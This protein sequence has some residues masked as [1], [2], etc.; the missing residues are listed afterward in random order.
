MHTK[1][2][3][4][5][6]PTARRRRRVPPAPAEAPDEGTVLGD[7]GFTPPASPDRERIHRDHAS[8]ELDVDFSPLC[9]LDKWVIAGWHA[10]DARDEAVSDATSRTRR[11]WERQ[12][13]L[14][15]QLENV[16]VVVH[17]DTEP[18]P[19]ERGRAARTTG[20]D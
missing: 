20:V 16:L 6:D 4:W 2:L 19:A 14:V 18:Q 15:A 5:R 13:L 7:K 8:C 9:P 11:A 12:Q 17:P 10:V 3:S 1:G